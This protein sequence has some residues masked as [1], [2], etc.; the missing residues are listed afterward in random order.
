[1][2]LTADDPWPLV[3]Q[4][5]REVVLD[6]LARLP[7][8]GATVELTVEDDALHVTVTP[9]GIRVNAVTLTALEC[10]PMWPEWLAP[11]MVRGVFTAGTLTVAA[12]PDVMA[13]LALG[14]LTRRE[15]L[16]SVAAWLG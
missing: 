2:H 14:W 5:H 12:E 8:L 11:A 9:P 6:R 13:A 7:Q 16:N 3:L 1:M 15:W 4:Q 10:A